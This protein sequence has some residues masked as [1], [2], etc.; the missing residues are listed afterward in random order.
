MNKI[1]LYS[2]SSLRF[3]IQ[4]NGQVNGNTAIIFDTI[5][6]IELPFKIFFHIVVKNIEMPLNAQSLCFICMC[7]LLFS[8]C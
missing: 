8:F 3:M 7:I 5:K 1:I 6:I 4:N 2:L